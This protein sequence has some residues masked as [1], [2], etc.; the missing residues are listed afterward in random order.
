MF[1]LCSSTVYCYI[2]YFMQVFTQ[3]LDTNMRNIKR[4]KDC[5][6]H[7][8]SQDK[9][10]Y[11]ASVKITFRETIALSEKLRRSNLNAVN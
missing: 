7:T 5:A 11:L 3:P 10:H 8:Q 6:L 4:P 9:R 2:N 1:F